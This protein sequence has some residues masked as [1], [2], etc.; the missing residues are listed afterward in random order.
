MASISMSIDT[1]SS[2]VAAE[3]TFVVDRLASQ[4]PTTDGIASGPVVAG[5]ISE[6]QFADWAIWTFS[7]SQSKTTTGQVSRCF[8]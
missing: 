8:E 5:T 2:L 1:L 4:F 3:E 6:V 7:L